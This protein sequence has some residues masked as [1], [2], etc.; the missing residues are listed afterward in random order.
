MLYKKSFFCNSIYYHIMATTILNIS[1][2]HNNDKWT[3]PHCNKEQSNNYTYKNHLKICLVRNNNMKEKN[4][5]ML[6]LKHELINEFRQEFIN[7]LDEIK[8]EIKSDVK[9]NV[10]LSTNKY[11]NLLF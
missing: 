4:N 10:T 1:N 5:I 7:M 3:C 11:K 2:D 8:D 6:E 9:S